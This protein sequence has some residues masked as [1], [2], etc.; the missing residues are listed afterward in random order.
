MFSKRR[1]QPSVVRGDA[2]RYL[3][4]VNQAYHRW[5]GPLSDGDIISEPWD[6]LILLDACRHDYFSRICMDCEPR[7]VPASSSS[8][9]V[10]AFYRGQDLH[11]TVYVGGNPFVEPVKNNFY[12]S[13]TVGTSEIDGGGVVSP[14]ETTVV[15][16]K[17]HENHPHKR[18][19]VHYMQ[20]HYPFVGD[21]PNVNLRRRGQMYYPDKN[22]TRDALKEAYAA[23]LRLVWGYVETLIEEIDGSVVVSADH[24]ELLGERQFPIP[25]RGY[26][27]F[28]EMYVPELTHVPWAW[29]QKNDRRKTVSETPIGEQ[30]N[31]T[32]DMEEWL[33]YLG[34][35]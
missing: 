33:E 18:I 23:N 19:I 32:K 26:E 11:D 25:V 17:A 10:D 35:L 15:A 20:P 9:Y 5:R 13:Y 27:H 31:G 28:E 6:T 8:E 14:S 22:T 30:Y 21:G 24:G 16:R 34:Y 1:Y 2:N 12:S 4:K 7:R 29:V 3:T